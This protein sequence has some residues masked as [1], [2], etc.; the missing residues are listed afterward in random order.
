MLNEPATETIVVA[1][2]LPDDFPYD[3][4]D[5]A[6]TFKSFIQD[7]SGGILGE[8]RLFDSLRKSLPN[9]QLANSDLSLDFGC[10]GLQDST[11][12]KRIAQILRSVNDKERLNFILLI[13]S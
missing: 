12:P 4:Y 6:D 7:L 9:L 11:N 1:A 3:V 8:V 13:F 10:R 5:V 2:N